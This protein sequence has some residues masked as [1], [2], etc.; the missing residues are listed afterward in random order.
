MSDLA[1]TGRRNWLSQP[2][3]RI[4][5]AAALLLLLA[6]FVSIVWTPHPIDSVNVG[7]ALQGFGGTHWLGTDYLGRDLLSL[8]MKGILASF[9]V[10][11]IAVVIGALVGIPLGLAAASWG[12]PVEWAILRLTH[13][14]F[15]F[16]ALIAAILITALAGPSMVNVMVAVGLFNIPAFARVAHAGMASFWQRDYVAAARLS[17]MSG[18]EVARRHILPSLVGLLGAQAVLQLALGII[19]EAGLSYV[20]L[21]TQPPATSLGLMLKDAQTYAPMQ[22]ALVLVPGIALLLIV[23]ALHLVSDGLRDRLDAPLRQ[24]GADRAA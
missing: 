20:G 22:P 18:A 10:A 24:I 1:A 23:V 19:A 4:G 3:L 9:I 11:A 8:L 14:M 6:G 12:G 2:G 5:I 21:G 13:F 17:G 16:P 7:A 15:A